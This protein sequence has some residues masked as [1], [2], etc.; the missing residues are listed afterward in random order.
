MCTVAGLTDC[1]TQVLVP[2]PA[3]F[4]TGLIFPYLTS[5]APDG[6]PAHSSVASSPCASAGAC[7]K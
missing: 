5:V 7:T 3:A 1:V 6:V 4:K 2:G